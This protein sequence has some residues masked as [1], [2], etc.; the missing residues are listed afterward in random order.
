MFRNTVETE[1]YRRQYGPRPL[2][3]AYLR[4]QTR[5]QV[6][7]PLQHLLHERTSMLRYTYIAYIV[8]TAKVSNLKLF[9]RTLSVL[10]TSLDIIR[11][12]KIFQIRKKISASQLS[13]AY[14]SSRYTISSS[15]S[16]SS[17]STSSSG[18]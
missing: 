18:A 1:G 6:S 4:L 12:T 10:N 16:S 2:H 7:F 9:N 13:R 15:S 14:L 11:D 5:T 8:T 3:A 17:S